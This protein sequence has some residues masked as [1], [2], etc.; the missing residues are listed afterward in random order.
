MRSCEDHNGV[1]SANL[2]ANWS[3]RRVPRP[4]SRRSICGFDGEGG[5]LISG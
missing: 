3:A 5:I 2:T 4:P 1:E